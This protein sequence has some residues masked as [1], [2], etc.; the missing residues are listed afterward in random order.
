ML[1]ANGV[2]ESNLLEIIE[3][4]KSNFILNYIG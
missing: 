2:S 1:T 4:T 3:K